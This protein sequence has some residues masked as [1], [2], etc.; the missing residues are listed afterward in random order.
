MPLYCFECKKCKKT[1]DAICIWEKVKLVKCDCGGKTKKLVTN[2]NLKFDN[3]KESSKWDNFGYRAGYNME[4]AK[5]ER[6]TAE[7]ATKDTCPYKEINDFN[8]PGVFDKPQ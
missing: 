6:R 8:T 2:C 3:P 7:A 4:K 5:E 1:F